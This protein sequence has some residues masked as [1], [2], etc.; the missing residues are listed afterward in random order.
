[1]G[2]DWG[3]RQNFENPNGITAKR[4]TRRKRTKCGGCGG[5]SS[6]AKTKGSDKGSI[7]TTGHIVSD[8]NRTM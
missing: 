3:M 2:G 6:G 7:R 1:M 5:K 4:A 8:G